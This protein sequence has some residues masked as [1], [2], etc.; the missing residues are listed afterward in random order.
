MHQEPEAE[1]TADPGCRGGGVR[2]HPPQDAGGGRLPLYTGRQRL[3][4]APFIRRQGDGE[5][6]TGAWR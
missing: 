5:L 4:R 1:A 6:C 2:T 3:D